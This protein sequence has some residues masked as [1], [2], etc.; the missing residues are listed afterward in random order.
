MPDINY[1]LNID[2]TQ[3]AN[4]MSEV[5]SQLNMGLA[6]NG[7]GIVDTGRAALGGL[8]DFGG[9]A[10]AA[11][12]S[13]VAGLQNVP[14]PTLVHADR[15]ISYTPH[16]GVVNAQASL[17]AEWLGRFYGPAGVAPFTP[18]GV[19]P[20]EYHGFLMR[21]H[22][23]KF[24]EARTDAIIAGGGAA[25]GF[26]A[27]EAGFSLGG[28][29][30]GLAGG[31]LIGGPFGAA[32]GGLAGGLGGAVA[33]NKLVDVAV[34]KVREA[35][36]MTSELGTI[37]DARRNL[38]LDLQRQLASEA[39]ERSREVGMNPQET[40]DIVARMSQLGTMI[41]TT[42]LKEFGEQLKS[43]IVD[44]RDF[45]SALHTSTGQ[46]QQMMAHME[47]VYGM[48]GP[49]GADF[50]IS[51]AGRIGM[52]TSP[53]QV[54][55]MMR[56]GEALGTSAQIGVGFGGMFA[57]DMAAEAT[58]A[59]LSREGLQMAGGVGGFA[60]ALEQNVLG[61][62][63]SPM[64][65]LQ[66]AAAPGGQFNLPTNLGDTLNRGITN[67][68]SD[69]PRNFL[70]LEVGRGEAVRAMGAR[71]T[72][73]MAKQNLRNI[74]DMLGPLFGPNATEGD[75]EL[76][77][78]HFLMQQGMTEYQAKGAAYRF[79][80]PGARDTTGVG[81]SQA[82]QEVRRR[83]E[84][85]HMAYARSEEMAVKADYPFL[86]LVPGA[87]D[88]ISGVNHALGRLGSRA[89]VWEG[90][91]TE[92]E[93]RD[94]YHRMGLP[95]DNVSDQTM[96]DVERGNI[97]L[98]KIEAPGSSTELGKQLSKVAAIM[99]GH[100]SSVAE[101]LTKTQGLSAALGNFTGDA[102]DLNLSRSGRGAARIFHDE[103]MKDEAGFKRRLQDLADA[104]GPRGSAQGV[105]DRLLEVFRGTDYEKDMRRGGL[106]AHAGE[107]LPLLMA[108]SQAA[109]INL[110]IGDSSNQYLKAWIASEHDRK[111]QHVADGDKLKELAETIGTSRRGPAAST[112]AETPTEGMTELANLI[113]KEN[114]AID[115]ILQEV[116]RMQS[117]G[118]A[119]RPTH[120]TVGAN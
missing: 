88:V 109:G 102:R 61:N 25:A 16:Y 9:T 58:H 118:R 41:P 45:A 46:A 51:Q 13:I 107:A 23:R 22:E 36:E 76:L 47:R 117:H 116:R 64:G 39:L 105:H 15:N 73:E 12:G 24:S 79:L 44:I 97:D 8:Y 82:L 57:L 33:A 101:M 53:M 5:R 17:Q 20:T 92:N 31:A 60:G 6:S 52:G 42:D 34:G 72:E 30:G 14:M 74:V 99:G 18:P 108:Y 38:P 80:N 90:A 103:I 111:I 68:M 93:L 10:A 27:G 98:R 94:Y 56:G 43:V 37:I 115:G 119:R 106:G 48:R 50:L 120:A 55:G 85:D 35:R 67:I 110:G 11:G 81:V 29:L 7:F 86:S 71:R 40:A 83:R 54:Y 84:L 65:M 4:S 62:A 19:G 113:S 26:V 28:A 78:R 87:A 32:I 112:G 59:R 77:G 75:R 96:A 1:R 63:F 104:L 95:Y 91:H 70:A 114:R 100:G 21:E 66:I 49:E 69:F 3:L 2:T 89:S